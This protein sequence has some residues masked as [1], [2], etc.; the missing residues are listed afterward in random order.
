MWGTRKL[1]TMCEIAYFGPVEGK[2]TLEKQRT[3]SKH[4]VMKISKIANS[5]ETR[6]FRTS[7][8]E[9]DP[10]EAESGLKMDRHENRDFCKSLEIRIRRG[11]KR[12]LEKQTQASTWTVMK[13]RMFT[14]LLKCEPG[15]GK[16]TL[17]KQNQASKQHVMKITIF[18]KVLRG[19]IDPADSEFQ[20]LVFRFAQKR[21]FQT[22]KFLDE[23]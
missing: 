5:A 11:E 10:G 14:K 12:T 2:S 20:R 16:S 22:W 4:H 13:S 19:E 7:R 1:V 9:I 8:G 21:D 17:E 3:A 18:A 6:L 15:G 23:V